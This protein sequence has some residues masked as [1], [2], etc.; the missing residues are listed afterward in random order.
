M[1]QLVLY[2]QYFIA[3]EDQMKI[4]N[5]IDSL[6]FIKLFSV[7]ERM[8][9]AAFRKIQKIKTTFKKFLVE[10]QELELASKLDKLTL[11]AE[12]REFFQDI[13]AFNLA[14]EYFESGAF[15]NKY[16]RDL[17]KNI[18]NYV[19]QL[20]EKLEHAFITNNIPQ[21]VQRYIIQDQ[22]PFVWSRDDLIQSALAFLDNCSIKY[23]TNNLNDDFLLYYEPNYNC[24]KKKKRQRENQ[25]LLQRNDK[26]LQEIWIGKLFGLDMSELDRLSCICY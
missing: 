7:S 12:Y 5:E 9:V 1:A 22:N 4:F 25:R 3:N 10:K 26:L 19:K 15:L 14:K 8:K 11:K 17:N 6:D 24:I 18:I 20:F 16:E 23:E 21:F 2:N 13:K